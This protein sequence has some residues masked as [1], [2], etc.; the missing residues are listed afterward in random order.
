LQARGGAARCSGLGH[1][2]VADT[3]ASL[4]PADHRPHTSGT[5]CLHCPQSIAWL[6]WNCVWPATA[7][8]QNA[9]KQSK[10]STRHPL[11]ATAWFQARLQHPAPLAGHTLAARNSVG[12]VRC[13]G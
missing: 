5:Y 8:A 11:P 12:G 7:L 3:A 2:E 1:A 13:V 6:C 10:C 4:P 9:M